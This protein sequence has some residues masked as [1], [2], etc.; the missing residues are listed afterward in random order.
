MSSLHQVGEQADRAAEI[1]RRLRRFVT[2]AKP[3][4][5]AVDINALVR[6]VA[7]LTNI[8]ARM[9]QAEV[10]FELADP[11]PPVL[12]DRIQIEQV[13]V[14]LMRNAF[15]AMR[16]SPPESRRLTIRTAFDGAERIVGPSCATAAAAFL[17]T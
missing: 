2:K 11:L 14:N 6:D 9:A 12:G 10:C 16:D 1:I 3:V 8:D 13:V 5:T 17:P 4:Q 7:E 15:E